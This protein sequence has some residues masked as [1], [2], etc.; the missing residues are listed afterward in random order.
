[1]QRPKLKSATSGGASAAG[2]L[3][4][5]IK[6]SSA[7]IVFL[8]PL[9]DVPQFIDVCHRPILRFFNRHNSSVSHRPKH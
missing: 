9:T 6:Q 1:M 5:A 2:W 3:S 8:Q 4:V 7:S